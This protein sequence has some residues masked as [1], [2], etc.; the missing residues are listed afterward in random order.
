MQLDP[1]PST[2]PACDTR[3]VPVLTQEQRDLDHR[4]LPADMPVMMVCPRCT[5]LD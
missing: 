2:C 3:M 5:P 1:M 4:P